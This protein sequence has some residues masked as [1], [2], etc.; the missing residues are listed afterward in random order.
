[1]NFYKLSK[2]LKYRQISKIFTYFVKKLSV[3]K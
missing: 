1:M 2:I 3:M